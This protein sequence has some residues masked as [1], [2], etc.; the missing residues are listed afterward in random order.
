M[1]KSLK[2]E[3]GDG[4][5]VENRGPLRDGDNIRSSLY[6]SIVTLGCL[7]EGDERG[8]RQGHYSS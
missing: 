3:T 8:D 7:D 1:T 5:F 2:V 6:P 4:T